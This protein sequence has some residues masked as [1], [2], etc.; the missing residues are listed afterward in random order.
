MRR[1]LD[2]DAGYFSVETAIVMSAVMILLAALISFILGLFSG[3]DTLCGEG[4]DYEGVLPVTVHRVTNVIVETGGE[5]FAKL[6]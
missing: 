3:I 6:S 5:L 2:S 4:V 1:L